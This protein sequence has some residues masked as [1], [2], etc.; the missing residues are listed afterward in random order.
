MEGRVTSM[1]DGSALI[2]ITKVPLEH[3]TALE[4]PV[5]S[6]LLDDLAARAGEAEKPFD[7]SSAL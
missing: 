1:A 6:R 3:L 5:L 4:S 2:D 7:F